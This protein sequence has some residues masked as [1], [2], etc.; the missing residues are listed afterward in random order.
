LAAFSLCTVAALAASNLGRAGVASFGGVR[1]PLTCAPRGQHVACLRRYAG[2]DWGTVGSC[3]V[4]LYG[5]NRW[6]WGDE[7]LSGHQA[8]AALVAP[9]RWRVATFGWN[10]MEG[11]IVRGPANAWRITD[12][13]SALVAIAYGPDGPAVGLL[14]LHWGWDCFPS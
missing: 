12:A 6:I 3:V 11:Y 4:G 2:G 7:G 5:N 8:H 9:G 14:L 13:K 1:H 10:D